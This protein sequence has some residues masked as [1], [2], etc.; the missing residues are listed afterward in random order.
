MGK[1]DPHSLEN[2][3]HFELKLKLLALKGDLMC[4]KISPMGHAV[5]AV[6]IKLEH[7]HCERAN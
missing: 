2:C 6:I 4:W 3:G 7:S 5:E 1:C